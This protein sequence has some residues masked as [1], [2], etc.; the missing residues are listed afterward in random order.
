VTDFKEELGDY[1]QGLNESKVRTL[2]DIINFNDAHAVIEFPSGQGRQEVRCFILWK[3]TMRLL[4]GQSRA[5]D[6]ITLFIKKLKLIACN[7]QQ[8]ME[9]MRLWNG[10]TWMRW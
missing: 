4:Y 6:T 9:L 1:L 7:L 10:I 2:E 8:R 5:L 3:V